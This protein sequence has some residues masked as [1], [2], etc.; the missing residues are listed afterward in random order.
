M[1]EDCLTT[2]CHKPK[3]NGF[4][5]RFKSID[6]EKYKRPVVVMLP[7]VVEIEKMVLD[8]SLLL[9]LPGRVWP[10]DHLLQFRRRFLLCLMLT[11]SFLAPVPMSTECS[12]EVDDGGTLKKAWKLNRFVD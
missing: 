11:N 1:T 6:L 10:G 9:L 7:I 12:A 5:R 8:I 3:T 2:H 4:N